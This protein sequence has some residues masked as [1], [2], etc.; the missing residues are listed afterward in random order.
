MN[1]Y[2]N[3]GIALLAGALLLTGFASNALALTNACTTISNQATMTYNVGVIGFSI[4]SDDPGVG[5]GT[6]PTTF[7]VAS[8]I[9]LTNIATNTPTGVPTQT[10]RVLTFRIDNTGNE[11]ARYQLNLYDRDGATVGANTDNFSMSNV[12]VYSDTDNNYAAGGT[13]VQISA[14]PADQAGGNLGLAPDPGTETAIVA[15]GGTIYI[16]VVADVP[17]T[18]T[19]GQKD[20]FTLVAKAYHDTNDS[21]ASGHGTGGG[22]VESTN[23][24]TN[25]CSAAVVLG[26]TTDEDG[27]GGSEPLDL[28]STTPDG[29]EPATGYFLVQTAAI[30]VS[31]IAQPIWDPINGAGIGTAKAIPG[32]VVRYTITIT[33]NGASDAD[34]V[35][36]TDDIPPNTYLSTYEAVSATAPGAIAYKHTGSGG[37]YD[38]AYVPSDN[39]AASGYDDRVTS[40]EITYAAIA[41]GGTVRTITFPVYIQ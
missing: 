33:N 21:T 36:L 9:N 3:Y 13:L 29:D 39:P 4:D 27:A 10:D 14:A 22:W 2:K 31:K 6:D 30:T 37:L 40:L 1:R 23:A 32:A 34:S 15:P 25:G 41:G 8:L 5:G 28:D 19:N 26:D 7:R 18:A 20:L 38:A 11:D 17:G 35:S 12:R 16:H 24:T